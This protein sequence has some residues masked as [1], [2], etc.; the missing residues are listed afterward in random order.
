MTMGHNLHRRVARLSGRIP[1][2]RRDPWQVVAVVRAAL[3][4][5]RVKGYLAEAY[6]VGAYRA[7]HTDPAPGHRG[8]RGMGPDPD[9]LRGAREALARAEAV[10]G[11]HG[12][13]RVAD[14]LD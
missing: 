12:P 11:R 5:D 7:T 4:P 8:P 1:E 3:G 2:P 14:L 10:M 9:A 6:L 13:D